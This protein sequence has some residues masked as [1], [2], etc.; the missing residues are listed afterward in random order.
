MTRKTMQDR[1]RKRARKFIDLHPFRTHS[2]RSLLHAA[3]SNLPSYRRNDARRNLFYTQCT[4]RRYRKKTCSGLHG[5]AQVGGVGK[6]RVLS[7]TGTF[8]G[9]LPHQFDSDPRVSLLAR[10]LP[11]K[12]TRA[13]RKNVL[14][15]RRSFL[16]YFR[17]KFF[18]SSLFGRSRQGWNER[19][20]C[21]FARKSR[22]YESHIFFILAIS[23]FFAQRNSYCI[24]L[25]SRIF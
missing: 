5:R 2:P 15:A 19:I 25:S 7:R 12:A 23:F 16:D 24:I 21:Y 6:Q 17:L 13:N 4:Y 18:R 10:A 22:T 11:C 3:P 9:K 20:A 8:P 1:A 14:L